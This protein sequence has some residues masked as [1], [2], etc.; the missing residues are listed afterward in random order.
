M[1]DATDHHFQQISSGTEFSNRLLPASRT[2]MTTLSRYPP[3]L[4]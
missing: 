1:F 3:A 2:R 4:A